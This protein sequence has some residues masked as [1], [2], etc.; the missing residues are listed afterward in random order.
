M[1][2]MQLLQPEINK[3][4]DRNKNNPQKMNK[5]MMELYKHHRFNPFGG[6]LPMFLQMPIF[7]ALYQVLWRSFSFK[8]AGFLWMKDLSEPDRLFILPYSIPFFGNEVN[9]LPF[10][11]A[12]LMFLQQKFSLKLVSNADPSHVAQQ[13]IMARVVPIM[14]GVLFYKVASGLAL[15]FSTF[16]LLST[17]M[18]WKMSKSA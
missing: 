14:I 13:K 17:L 16:Y 1:K 11:V 4:R 18:Q 15:Y 3:I 5:E 10:L 6:C 2:K 12:V 9:A 8:G 7:I